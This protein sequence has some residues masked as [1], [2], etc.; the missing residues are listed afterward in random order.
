MYGVACIYKHDCGKKFRHY[1]IQQLGKASQIF[2]D[3][4]EFDSTLDHC[5]TGAKRLPIFES[6]HTMD[7]DEEI[8]ESSA[9]A[10]E[11]FECN[12]KSHQSSEEDASTDT[13]LESN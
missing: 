4:Q 7:V 8:D 2:K 3:D 13:D 1:Y 9:S 11:E 6:I 5:L 12:I 10:T